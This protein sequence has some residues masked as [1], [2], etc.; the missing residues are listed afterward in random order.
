MLIYFFLIR[1]EMKSK[2][3]EILREMMKNQ[4]ENENESSEEIVVE[5]KAKPVP[6]HVRRPIFS[7][8]VEKHPNR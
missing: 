6:S 3:K 5:F 7:E 4:E 1:E 8:M 2:E